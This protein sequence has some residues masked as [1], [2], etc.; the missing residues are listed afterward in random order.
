MRGPPG[1]R[2]SAPGTFVWH[3]YVA[4]REHVRRGQKRSQIVSVRG[5]FVGGRVV[6]PV[7]SRI[8]ATMRVK[9]CTD[10]VEPGS[11]GKHPSATPSFVGSS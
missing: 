11:G 6:L 2:T 9:H 7:V 3:R 10:S 5:I 8:K 4:L 1:H